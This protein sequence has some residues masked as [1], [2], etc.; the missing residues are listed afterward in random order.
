[1]TTRQTDRHAVAGLKQENQ[2]LMLGLCDALGV[3]AAEIFVLF[4]FPSV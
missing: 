3:E 1:M 2:T 4:M